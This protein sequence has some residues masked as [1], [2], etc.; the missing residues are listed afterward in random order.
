MKHWSN[1]NTPIQMDTRP[2]FI[3]L[4]IYSGSNLGLI[5]VIA[6]MKR[7]RAMPSYSS[8]GLPV[9]GTAIPIFL[10]FSKKL[11]PACAP[12]RSPST[13][14]RPSTHRRPRPPSPSPSRR[15]PGATRGATD[16]VRRHP[17]PFASSLAAAGGSRRQ[18]RAVVDEGGGEVFSHGSSS[19]T[20]LGFQAADWW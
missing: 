18:A 2:F 4:P 3:R 14:S 10:S 12:C 11:S 7:T 20:G 13:T 15:P 19:G 17:L 6:D 1:S 16:L 8:P 9:G 5:C